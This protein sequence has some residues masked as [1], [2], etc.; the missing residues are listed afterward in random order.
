QRSFRALPSADRERLVRE[1]T[2]ALQRKLE[3]EY[4]AGRVPSPRELWG[5]EWFRPSRTETVSIVV[6]VWNNLRF[7]KLCIGS[8]ERFTAPPFETIVVDNGSTDGTPEWLSSRPDV[9]AIRN[10]TNRGFAAAC[11]QGIEAARGEHVVLLNNDVV[12]T[13]DWLEL[14]HDHVR[15]DPKL[16]I[17]APRTNF[18]SGPQLVPQ[19]GYRSLDEL[20][21]YARSFTEANRGRRHD[22][23]RVTGLCMFVT[24]P[25]RRA[26]GLLDERFGIG[27][28]EDDDYCV[29]A[30]RAGFGVTI[31]LDVFVHHFGSQTFRALGVDYAGLLRENERKFREKWGVTSPPAGHRETTRVHPKPAVPL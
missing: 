8:I 18:S 23:P 7:T 19:V 27:N 10:E 26:V 12:V 21:G 9:R 15:V 6:P 4:G 22:F 5:I 16:G 14:L 13:P 25:C 29:R 28:F 24:G 20:E 31:A 30:R 2:D 3:R 1:S 17:V 11:N